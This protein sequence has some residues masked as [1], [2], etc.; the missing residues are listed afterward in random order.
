MPESGD[1]WRLL[2]TLSL[3][4]ASVCA[5]QADYDGNYA[6]G[7][8][9]EISLERQEGEFGLFCPPSLCFFCLCQQMVRREK[10]RA[11]K[12]NKTVDVLY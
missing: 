12:V 9:N 2:C 10:R 7:F 6:D 1:F 4:C 5:N 3:V 11:W 8:D